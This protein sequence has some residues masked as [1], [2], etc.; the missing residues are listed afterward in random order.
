M[1]AA[2]PQAV[3][4]DTLASPTSQPSTPLDMRSLASQPFASH[5]LQPLEALPA[6]AVVPA[7]A[8]MTFGFARATGALHGWN[9]H[10]TVGMALPAVE[11]F[12][13]TKMAE[14]GYKLSGRISKS[15]DCVEL[16]FLRG[17]K[18]S[19]WVNL[20]PADRENET[21]IILVI[22]GERTR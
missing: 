14:L 1:N 3:L 12:Y 15:P 5:E 20:R 18:E 22:S 8:E 17:G 9:L 10:L 2:R 21:L 7:G 6:G 4:T 19:Y 13:R 16:T 11:S